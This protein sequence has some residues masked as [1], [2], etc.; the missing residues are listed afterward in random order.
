MSGFFTLRM[1]QQGWCDVTFDG[2]LRMNADH[3]NV[4]SLIIL[5]CEFLVLCKE[6]FCLLCWFST[7][8]SIY[9]DEMFLLKLGCINVQKELK[10]CQLLCLKATINE[11]KLTHSFVLILNLWTI[12]MV[13]RL[14]KSW[15][16][17]SSVCSGSWF[18]WK[19]FCL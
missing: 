13:C 8:W 16:G 10:F 18:M 15:L 9:L 7:V 11:L 6:I 14:N 17:Q 19:W 1:G 5:I 4:C 12:N 3:V 2:Y